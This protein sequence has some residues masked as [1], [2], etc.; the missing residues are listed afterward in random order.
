MST[1]RAR[2]IAAVIVLVALIGA[3][4]LA[5]ELLQSGAST[6][7]KPAP[8]PQPNA[9]EKAL[10]VLINKQRTSRGLSALHYD[11]VMARAA[12]AH[13]NDM[14]ARDYFAH[15]EPNGGPTFAQ[16]MH[17]V[18]VMPGR[19]ALGENI[20]LG[21]GPYGSASALVTAWMNSPGHRANIL[22][23]AFHRTGFGARIAPGTYQGYPGVTVA[24]ED[25]S[26]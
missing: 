22:D 12:L 14:I 24:T 6:T 9:K 25:F 16:R 20:A 1:R 11:P 19:D 26:N 23:R 17:S 2:W 15:D 10:L 3:G 8:V 18:L 13:N 4:L 21:S 7:S 5:H